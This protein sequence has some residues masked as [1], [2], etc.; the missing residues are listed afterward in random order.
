[1]CCY[2]AQS[3]G[4]LK[5]LSKSRQCP[6]AVGGDKCAAILRRVSEAKPSPNVK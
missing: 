6:G 3:L 1:M 2:S 4:G 5:F